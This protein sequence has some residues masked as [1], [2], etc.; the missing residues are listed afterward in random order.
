MNSELI[1]ETANFRDTFKKHDY[2]EMHYMGKRP[3]LA[4]Y[5]PRY[6]IVQFP[7]KEVVV[8]T[9]TMDPKARIGKCFIT[10]YVSNVIIS[11]NIARI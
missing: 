6:F 2:A 4:C 9:W 10:I 3:F 5:A 1:R 7:N 8:K 11:Y